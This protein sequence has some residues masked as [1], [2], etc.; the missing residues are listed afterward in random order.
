MLLP[1]DKGRLSY[2]VG[3]HGGAVWSDIRSHILTHVPRVREALAAKSPEGAQQLRPFSISL[4]L[5]TRA[6]FEIEQAA[7]LEELREVLTKI[8]VD[9]CAIDGSEMISGRAGRSRSLS[10]GLDW[11]TDERLRHSDRLA[12]LLA[13]IAGPEQPGEPARPIVTSPGAMREHGLGFGG[14]IADQ[15]LQHVAGL[16]AIK[17]RTGRTVALAVQHEPCFF[18]GSITE[19]AAFFEAHLFN[20]A[21][22][23]RLAE[24]TGLSRGDSAAALPRHLGLCLDTCHAALGFE[25]VSHGLEALRR[26]G[27]PV[28]LIRLSSA[29]KIPKLNAAARVRLTALPDPFR[30]RQVVAKNDEGKLARHIDL[31]AALSMGLAATG[32]EWRVRLRAP[33]YAD[34]FEAFSST[35]DVARLVLS[36]HKERR[37]AGTLEV[38]ADAWDV[39]PRAERNIAIDAAIAR[40]MQWVRD[41]LA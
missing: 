27:A 8:D 39:L 21:G 41:E 24:L 26:V 10:S 18:I 31:A 30:L 4:R 16:I 17:A 13:E 23:A 6:A 12:R 14:V 25:D 36:L 38:V 40:E 32:D 11:R 35:Q 34:R 33:V 2:D 15:M 9:L 28:H 1:D 5:T 19:A 20:E 22:A 37:I 7:A 3:I 29:V